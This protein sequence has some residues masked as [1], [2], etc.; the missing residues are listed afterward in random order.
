[1]SWSVKAHISYQSVQWRLTA[2]SYIVVIPDIYMKKI[3]HAYFSHQYIHQ[4]DSTGFKVDKKECAKLLA[5]TLFYVARLLSPK[6]IK[7]MLFPP[8][9]A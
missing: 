6:L 5:W 9:L 7:S 4:S 1:M 2:V 8:V 3:F